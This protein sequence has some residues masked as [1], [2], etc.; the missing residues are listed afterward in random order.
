[1]PA[2]TLDQQQISVINTITVPKGLELTAEKVRNDYIEYFKQQAGFVSSTFYRSINNEADGSVKYVNIVVWA[3]NSHFEQV[4][5]LGFSHA[6]G[7]NKDGKKVLGKGFPKPITVS[8]GQ[9]F[10]LKQD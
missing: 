1:M 2:S 6:E 9:Y 5:N 7:E 4:V 3:S 8:P 10:V